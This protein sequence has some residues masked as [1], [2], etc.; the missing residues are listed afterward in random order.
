MKIT[1]LPLDWFTTKLSSGWPFSFARYGDGEWAA[2]LNTPGRTRDGQ[3][4][5]AEL[6]AD[7]VASL[8]APWPFA[9]AISP[10]AIRTYGN[11]IETW[12]AEHRID[13]RWY[14]SEVFLTASITG[15][16]L[17]FIT[18]LRARKV[19]YVGPP[20]LRTL[21]RLLPLVDF[22]ETPIHNAH[23]AK[24]EL[25][26]AIRTRRT[27]ADVVLLSCG[28]AATVLVNDLWKH[29][30]E[31]TLIDLGSLFDPYCGV[32]SRSYMTRH[33]WHKLRRENFGQEGVP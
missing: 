20:H 15:T 33:N 3:T 22:I 5:T 18:A 31:H 32:A 8:A 25:A 29:L 26:H 24:A 1:S 7:L 14:D 30:P 16:L 19:V 23:R 4:Y 12:L 11:P 28:P 10:I 21:T 17:P 2:I 13:V 27:I 6:G 9:H